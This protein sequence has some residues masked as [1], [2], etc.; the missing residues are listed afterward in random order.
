MGVAR[1]REIRR[2]K[3]KTYNFKK[4]Q[5][6]KKL[7]NTYFTKSKTSEKAVILQKQLTCQ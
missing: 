1:N 7:T 2:V 5:F 3:L 4:P 6:M